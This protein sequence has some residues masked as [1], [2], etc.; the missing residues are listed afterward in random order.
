MRIGE[1]AAAS[2]VSTRV[3]RHYEAQGLIVSRRAGNGYRDYERSALEQVGWIRDLLDCGFG[4]RQIAGMMRCLHGGGWDPG[5]C[6]AG[7]ALHLRKLNELDA[8]IRLLQER[9]ERL[10]R[11]LRHFESAPAAPSP[12][13]RQTMEAE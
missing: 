10:A 13:R 9:R 2:G 8:T 1:L 5:N 6:A 12:D 3:L 7:Y 4:T 11:R